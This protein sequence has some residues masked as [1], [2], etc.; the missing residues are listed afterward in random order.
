MMFGVNT[1][2]EKPTGGESVDS[3]LI[4]IIVGAAVLI[5]LV[6]LII[7]LVSRRSRRRRQ[8]ERHERTREEFGSEYD[9]AAQESGSRQDAE[10]DLRQ[11][12][13]QMERQVRP[14]SDESR[15]R[16][17]ERWQEVERV[18]VENPQRSVEIADRAVADLLEERNVVADAAQSD[19]DTQRSL[20]VLH[21]DVADD[22]QAARRVRANV[23]GRAASGEGDSGESERTE[24]RSEETEEMRDAVR[25]YRTVYDRLMEQ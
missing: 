23:V 19:S 8:E 25:R 5:L 9:R 6:L 12:R 3:G 4:G 18:F 7:Y 11:R 20:G 14:L 21:P 2:P 22:Y 16:Y 10:K 13:S 24:S 17:G 15:S 1:L